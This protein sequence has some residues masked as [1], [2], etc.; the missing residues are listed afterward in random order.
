MSR[1]GVQFS[2]D[3]DY[4]SGIGGH[5]PCFDLAVDKVSIRLSEEVFA[6]GRPLAAVCHGPAAFHLV[7]GPDGKSIFAGRRVTCFSNEEEEQVGL[8]KVRRTPWTVSLKW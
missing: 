7:K 1:I 4:M 6:S 2:A 3:T 5:G 8:T